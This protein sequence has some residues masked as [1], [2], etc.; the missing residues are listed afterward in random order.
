MPVG[1][2]IAV[3]LGLLGP[4]AVPLSPLP[5]PVGAPLL[6]GRLLVIAAVAPVDRFAMS[7]SQPPF[8]M[9]EEHQREDEYNEAHSPVYVT[10]NSRAARRGPALR[11]VAGR[12]VQHAYCT[13]AGRRNRAA[14]APRTGTVVGVV[15]RNTNPC[16]AAA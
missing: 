1:V 12:P 3:A 11:P 9:A 10:S 14:A 6:P 16:A 13:N 2:P 15:G 5:P 4:E 8:E 7:G